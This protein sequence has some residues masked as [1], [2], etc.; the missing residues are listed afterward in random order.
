MNPE[1]LRACVESLVSCLS[2]EKM[3]TDE[4]TRRLYG[5][6]VS[7]DASLPALVVRPA[8]TGELVEV[9]K[10]IAAHDLVA[11]P[12]GGGMSYSSGYVCHDERVVCIDTGIM[13]EVLEINNED[14]YVTVQAGCSWKK[15]HDALTDHGLRTPFWGTLSGLKASVGGSLSQNSIFWGSCRHGTAADS[16]ISFDIVLA[17][18]EI[19]RT[20]SAAQKNSVPFFRHYG[21]DLT[22]IFTADAGALGLKATATLKLIP[23]VEGRAYV[24]FD[25]ERHEPLF[26]ALAEVS[27]KRLA[28]AC[29]GM[30]PGLQAARKQRDSLLND[31]KTLKGVVTGQGSLLR[32]L[33]EGVRIAL[34]GRGFIDEEKFSVHY[35]IE[36]A[37]QVAADAGA[38]KIRSICRGVGGREIENNIPSVIRA[39]PFMPLNNMIGPGG[40]RWLPV[41]TLVPHSRATA[42]YEA[43]E[44]VFA[45]NAEVMREHGIFHAWLL[46]SIDSQCTVLE[47]VFYWPDQLNALHRA[48]VEA[49][50]L[51]RIDRYAENPAGF[52]EVTRIREELMQLMSE[53]GGVHLQIGRRYHYRDGIS[54]QADKLLV[55]LKKELDPDNR[56]N[57]GALGL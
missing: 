32:G 52:A 56:I 19:L 53:R 38:D 1:L 24:S 50:T 55:H 42:V 11:V 16:V 2:A 17:N 34:A 28:E 51:S 21:P 20:G 27:R 7:G 33:K 25:F 43:I 6:D 14:M 18:G 9:M 40:E 48:T 49:R 22:G 30:D 45:K 46:S 47:P 23:V 4:K 12:R 26:A 54:G 15:L 41:H 8:N 10:I 5:Q 37:T 35:I 3:R 31:A 44:A 13:D 36:E 39:N 29:F 57:P